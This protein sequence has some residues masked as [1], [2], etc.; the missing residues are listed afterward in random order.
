MRSIFDAAHVIRDDIIQM[1]TDDGS[2]KDIWTPLTEI[3]TFHTLYIVCSD[4][5]L[6]EQQ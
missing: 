4:G 2:L 1:R 3:N 5:L 6:K